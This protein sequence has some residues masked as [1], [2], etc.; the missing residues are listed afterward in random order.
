MTTLHSVTQRPGALAA[1]YAAKRSDVV[2]EDAGVVI[3]VL[4]DDNKGSRHQ[5]FILRMESGTVLVAHNI[6]LAPRVPNLDT[7][8]TIRFKGEYEYNQKGGVIHW[9]HH[10][11]KG[12]H[13]GG[14]LEHAGERYQ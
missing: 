1:A 6:D 7:G 14:W 12:Y 4:P 9:T 2:L 3:K 8:D 5:R 10:D 11:P 13:E